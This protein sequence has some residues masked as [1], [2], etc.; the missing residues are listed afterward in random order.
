MSKSD[1][2][3]SLDND[4]YPL[5]GYKCIFDVKCNNKGEKILTVRNDLEQKLYYSLSGEHGLCLDT[6]YGSVK[7]GN[8]VQ[9]LISLPEDSPQSLLSYLQETG[10]FFAIP[11]NYEYCVDA[12]QLNE[13]VHRIKAT[14]LLMS[15]ISEP[16]HNYEQLIKYVLY[17]LFEKRIEICLN[18]RIGYKSCVHDI[19]KI[20]SQSS[21]IPLNDTD[22]AEANEKG[23]Y[24]VEDTVY[25]KVYEINAEEYSDITTGEK[26]TFD[27]PGIDDRRYQVL[28]SVY[29]NGTG[30]GRNDRIVIDFLFHFMNV[31][32]VI[33]SVSYADGITFY[34]KPK[35]EKMDKHLKL[36]LINVARIAISKEIN[37]NIARMKPYYNPKK[38]EPLWIAPNLIT[39]YYFALFYMRPGKE[40]YRKCVNPSCSGY[41]SVKTSNAR[42]KY[43]DAKCRNASN[44][45]DHRLREKRKAHK[46]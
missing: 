44:Q 22:Y 36:G 35:M 42:K 45:R 10:F 25:R 40:I 13:I 4:L 8:L 12:V 7:E 34:A 20:L 46:L 24:S 11:Q 37:Y 15:G 9:K 27:Y 33:K 6:H 5:E 30:L 2:T 41:F 21:I 31:V 19:V 14:V 17:L 23:T 3:Y 29:K 1:E 43:C 28:T 26:F 38:L 39:A 18:E 32:G 16:E